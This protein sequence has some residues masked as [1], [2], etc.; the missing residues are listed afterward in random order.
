MEN[1]EFEKT[2][3][4]KVKR[5]PDR[6]SYDAAS[7]YP[8][9]D[10]SLICHVGFV[11]HGRAVVIPTIHARDNDKI[12]LHG[13]SKSRMMM[14]IAAGNEVCITITHLDGLVLA[15]SVFHHSMNYRSAV[16]YGKGIIIE[17]ADAKMRALQIF[18]DKLIPGRWDDARQPTPLESKATT[19]VEIPIELASAKV[20]VGPPGDDDEDY[21]LDVWAGVL[22]MRKIFGDLVV[23][24]RL[25]EGIDVPQY[26]N[27][28]AAS[29]K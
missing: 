22:P 23:D 14:H 6:G 3:V 8:I 26:I 5:V 9:V 16:L 20:R 15:R 7:I 28:Y 19:I 12:L 25:K 21:A 18:T 27:D 13:S 24:P 11:D 10:D 4:N 17:D 1:K 2:A 29:R